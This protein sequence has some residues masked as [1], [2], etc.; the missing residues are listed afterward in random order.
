LI[1]PRNLASAT[2]SGEKGCIDEK[3]DGQS[4]FSLFEKSPLRGA[5]Q[6]YVLDDR[7]HDFHEILPPKFSLHQWHIG[8][9]QL[10]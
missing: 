9:T 4:D 5:E 6:Q 2:D 10:S 1:S 8:K 3:T 7:P